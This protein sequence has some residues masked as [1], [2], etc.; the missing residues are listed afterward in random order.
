MDKIWKSFYTL[1]FVTLGKTDVWGFSTKQNS[2]QVLTVEAFSTVLAGEQKNLKILSFR[3]GSASYL[4][5][6]FHWKCFWK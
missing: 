6:L 5:C 4:L 1:E 3:L 2:E